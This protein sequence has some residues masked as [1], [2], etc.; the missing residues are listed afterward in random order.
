MIDSRGWNNKCYT[1]ETSRNKWGKGRIVSG[2]CDKHGYH[3]SEF[4]P[5]CEVEEKI[6]TPHI[7]KWDNEWSYL[8]TG[9]RMSK[10]ELKAYCRKN[11]KVWIG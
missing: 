11:G 4:C 7:E 9:R 8:A 6:E 1:V 2:I 10:S 3:S 5:K